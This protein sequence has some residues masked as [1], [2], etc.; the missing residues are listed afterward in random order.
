M[1]S[2]RASAKSTLPATTWASAAA[3]RRSAAWKTS[4]P[5]TRRGTSRKARM[6]KR[7]IR[8]PL[9]AEVT[10]SM[11]P[12]KHADRHR[13]ELVAAVHRKAPALA[14][15]QPLDEQGADQRHD[16][17]EKDRPREHAEEQRLEAVAGGA[18]EGLK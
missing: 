6:R 9:P 7:A 12:T 10:P 1:S 4:V 14:L 17:G 18:L 8:A 3:H 13:R 11:S 15:V 5:T 2:V 16:A